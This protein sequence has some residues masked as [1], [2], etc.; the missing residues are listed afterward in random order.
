MEFDPRLPA[1]RWPK[2]RVKWRMHPEFGGNV[3]LP[4]GIEDSSAASPRMQSSS[5][6]GSHHRPS[7]RC[8]SRGNPKTHGRHNRRMWDTGR[9]SGRPVKPSTSVEKGLKP[10]GNLGSRLERRWKIGQRGNPEPDRREH[11]RE[12]LRGDSE[13]H[14]PVLL[15]DEK[16][17]ETADSPFGTVRRGEAGATRSRIA[18]LQG[19]MHGT[20]NLRDHHYETPERQLSGV[21]VCAGQLRFALS[22][23]KLPH[24]KKI[25]AAAMNPING[26]GQPHTGRCRMIAS[27]KTP[28]PV[29]VYRRERQSGKSS[30][31]HSGS[32]RER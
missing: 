28:I 30:R 2:V 19:A 14:P 11:W 3:Q 29:S 10:W 32:W 13:N 23:C 31:A 24:R 16:M 15:K 18:R 26:T 20:S 8:R 6:F 9:L 1:C 25:K 7:R 5:P 27:V 4:I 12:R 22:I 21:F 17:R